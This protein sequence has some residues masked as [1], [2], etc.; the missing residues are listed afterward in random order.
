M[1]TLGKSYMLFNKFED[2]ENVNVSINA[3][4]SEQI[5]DAANET[6]NRNSL[7]LLIFK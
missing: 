3:I 5:M 1:F 2:L 6:L 7:S 4:T